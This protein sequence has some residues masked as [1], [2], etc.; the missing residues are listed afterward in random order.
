[1]ES[2]SQDTRL[3]FFS[4]DP[5][6]YI[7]NM[8][9]KVQSMYREISQLQQHV[10]Y[11][12]MHSMQLETSVQDK[13]AIIAS[14]NALHVRAVNDC[15]DLTNGLLSS[16]KQVFELKSQVEDLQAQLADDKEH[17]CVLVNHVRKLET[18]AI[19]RSA[20]VAGLQNKE[21]TQRVNKRRVVSPENEQ[22][23]SHAKKVQVCKTR[24][25]KA[26]LEL[27]NASLAQT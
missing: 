11:E 20:K 24:A 1:M 7:A 22:T 17:V 13:N 4:T 2:Y 14:L 10:N 15:S 12:T 8:N 21:N 27:Q 9:N 19:K 23:E 3:T 18:A 16:N 5:C 25:Q 26:S 6:E